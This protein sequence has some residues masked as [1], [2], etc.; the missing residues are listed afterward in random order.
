LVVIDV[1]SIPFTNPGGHF[2]H[3]GGALMGWFYIFMLR[4][5]RDLGAP[6]R[7]IA[8]FLGNPLSIFKAKPKKKRSPKM[9]YKKATEPA[10]SDTSGNSAKT[11]ETYGRSFTQRYRNMSVDECIDAILDKINAQGYD[12]LSQEE[13]D[14]LAKTS[15]KK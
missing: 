3:L 11:L 14:F 4:R 9:A 12:S 15:K 8:E 6:I 7:S 2:A 5:G 10:V 1:L 13:K